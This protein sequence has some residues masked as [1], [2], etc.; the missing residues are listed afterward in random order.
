MCLVIYDL[1][2]PLLIRLKHVNSA[3]TGLK[4]YQLPTPVQHFKTKLGSNIFFC[5]C[6]GSVIDLLIFYHF[7][8]I[9]SVMEVYLESH[10]IV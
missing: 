3:I 9:L 5:S 1:L 4:L 6:I 2:T 7:F 8:S 10:S